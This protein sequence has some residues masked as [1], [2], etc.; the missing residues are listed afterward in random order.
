M[1]KPQ[2]LKRGDTVAIVSLSS[3]IAGDD[4]IIWRTYQGIQRLQE[5]FGLK[6]KIMP[7]ALKG[8]EFIQQ[9]PELRASDLNEAIRDREVKAIISCIGGDDAIRIWPYV[10]REAL[11]KFPKIFSGYSDSTTVHMMFYKM[12]ITSFYGPALLTDFAENINM[13]CYTI[14]DIE[15]NWFN[16]EPIGEVR[17]AK[18]IR[19]YGLSWDVENKAI[20][21]P[22]I[23]QQ[24]YIFLQGQGQV[25]IKGHLIGGNLETLV[26]I[27]DSELFP[28]LNDFEQAILFLE[29]SEDM[30]NPE[31]FRDM[32]FQLLKKGV[33]HSV[34]GIIFGKPFNNTYYEQYKNEI[35]TFFNIESLKQLPI[36]YNLSFGHNE[37]KHILPY[38]VE[39]QINCET[40]QFFITENAVTED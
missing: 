32:L 21:R 13:D 8:S 36:L 6:V 31:E 34:N 39:A 5:V 37:P 2:K 1:L 30:P 7:H 3:G 19:P 17:P 14:K 4:A 10:D 12:G 22:V 15:N 18:Y 23:Q 16:S 27:K 38:G 28:Q 20:A 24:G 25:N 11:Q 33:F 26:D 9:H 29:T 35:L 40:K